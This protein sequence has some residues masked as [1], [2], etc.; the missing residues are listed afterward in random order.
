MTYEKLI[1]K[2]T[3]R[4]TYLIREYVAK[5]GYEENSG[6]NFWLIS[7]PIIRDFEER[8]DILL[9]TKAE[10]NK[11]NKVFNILNRKAGR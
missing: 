10:G 6:K 5:N 3:K 11:I 7:Q 2:L 8:L 1:L 9:L 4:Q